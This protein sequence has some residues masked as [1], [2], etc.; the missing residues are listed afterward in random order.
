VSDGYGVL[1]RRVARLLDRFPGLKR[2]VKRGY[3]QMNYHLFADSNFQFEIYSNC[4]LQTPSAYFGTEPVDGSFFFGYYD[5]T[6]WSPDMSR[7]VFHRID[8]AADTVD[9]V[10]FES[11]RCRSIATSKAWNYQQGSLTRWLPESNTDIIFN[12]VREG[13]LRSR[14]VDV[15]SGTTRWLPYPFQTIHPT[16]S[17]ALTINYQRFDDFRPDYGY[18]SISVSSE[19]PD[20][21]GIWRFDTDDS[22]IEELVSIDELI[23]SG[24]GETLA[25]ERHKIN[26]LAY[27]P[28]GSKFAFMHRWQGESGR[29]SR[30]Y[31]ANA[32]GS[33][34]R[35]LLDEGVVSHYCW[36]DSSTLLVWG[37]SQTYGED[38]YLIDVESGTLD[39][40]S[41]LSGVGDGHPSI[42]PDGRWIVTDTYPDRE[43]RRHLL[44][45]D[46]E[47]DALLEVGAFYSPLRFDGRARC[48]LHPRWSPDGRFVSFDSTHTGQR[49]SYL[50]DVSDI[51]T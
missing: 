32:N 8:S 12:D 30:L 7:A 28:D 20:H 3:R 35:L 2:R 46:L 15:R 16:E 4:S 19:L 38:Y 51:V 18:P 11:D 10:T 14:I 21:E 43:A 50:L 34:R 37:N 24:A 13:T 25:P 31:V 48:D 5:R 42:S 1:E 33:D 47:L 49:G 45:Y 6:P 44:L 41:E 23:E 9:I 40:L 26:H 17:I 27:A 36:T 29:Q 22:S 39:H